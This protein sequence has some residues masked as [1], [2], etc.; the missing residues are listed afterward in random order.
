MSFISDLVT[1][2]VITI[3]GQLKVKKD[4]TSGNAN[5]DSL[6]GRQIIDFNTLFSRSDGK[7]EIDGDM[8]VVA[9]THIE[10]DKD[11]FTFVAD[12]LSEN[13]RELLHM[14][15]DAVNAASTARAEIIA[16]L[17]PN[18]SRVAGGTNK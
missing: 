15:V 13:D 9:A 7:L 18:F 6:D 3:T 8:R 16:R 14:H 1:L 10:I 5:D 4:V 11:T 2:D 12:N 17:K